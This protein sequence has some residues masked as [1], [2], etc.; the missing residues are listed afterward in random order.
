ML[1]HS[2]SPSHSHPHTHSL[3][4]SHL[5]ALTH[6]LSLTLARTHTL[7][8]SHLHARTHTLSAE[9]GATQRD[10]GLG[11]QLPWQKKIEETNWKRGRERESVGERGREMES[12]REWE[13]ERL[14]DGVWKGEREEERDTAWGEREESQKFED[15]F[16]FWAEASFFESQLTGGRRRKISLKRN[17]KSAS[18]FFQFSGT[19]LFIFCFICVLLS[20]YRR[21]GAA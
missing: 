14:W 4:L 7:S 2:F 17:L 15:W 13:R 1:S 11:F 20:T 16:S 3:S 18:F 6:T 8:L 5:H 10:E 9:M 21:K 19:Y 12:G